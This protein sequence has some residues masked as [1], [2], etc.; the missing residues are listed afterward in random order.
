MKDNNIS[1]GAT[2]PPLG[3]EELGQNM[4]Y[5]ATPFI[6]QRAT[7]LRNNTTEAE[8][9]LWSFISN[10]KLGLKFRRQHPASQ[11][12]LDFYAHSIKLAIELD[13]SIHSL[14]EVKKND[15]VRQEHLESLGIH[16]MRFDNK[17]I[18]ANATGVV[19]KIKLEVER[20]TLLS[21]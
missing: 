18:F 6:F 2:S 8:N 12:I 15:G 9:L 17:E 21:L 1:L 13:G 10:N 4:F 16:F 19:D 20:L 3:T 14:E 5:Q 11:Y 7:E